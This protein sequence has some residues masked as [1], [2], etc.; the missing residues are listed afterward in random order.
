MVQSR[1]FETPGALEEIQLAQLLGE[2]GGFGGQLRG[3]LRHPLPHDLQLA[4][5][6]GI[7][8]PVVEAAP[9]QGVRV[10]RASGSR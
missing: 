9:F 5:V 6:A 2:A 8:D 3:R 10:L 1:G 4:F 7:R